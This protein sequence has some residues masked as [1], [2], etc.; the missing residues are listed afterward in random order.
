MQVI[1]TSQG[2]VPLGTAKML[3]AEEK[4]NIKALQAQ[5]RAEYEARQREEQ[6]GTTT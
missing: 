2:D 1:T 4:A 5:R 6:S 3:T